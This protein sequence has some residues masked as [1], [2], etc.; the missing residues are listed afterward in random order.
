MEAIQAVNESLQKITKDFVRSPFDYLYERD[1]QCVLFADIFNRMRGSPITVASRTIN[2]LDPTGRLTINPVKS[3]YPSGTRFDIAII[4][5]HNNNTTRRIWNH[6]VNV[7]IEIKLWQVD[8]TGGSIRSDLSKL[9]EYRSGR[10]GQ[11]LGISLLFCQPGVN[12]SQYLNEYND[13]LKDT[14]GLE[15]INDGLCLY[16]IQANGH[17]LAGSVDNLHAS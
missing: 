3:E 4:D 1:I 7:A 16:V 2:N 6:E 8:G 5:A 12:H 11:F 15:S 9:A 10:E 17:C 14:N 13:L